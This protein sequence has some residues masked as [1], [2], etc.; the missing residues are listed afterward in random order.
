MLK[1]LLNYFAKI[2]QL[3]IEFEQKNLIKIKKASLLGKIN[4]NNEVKNF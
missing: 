2:E 1:N 4:R 3:K